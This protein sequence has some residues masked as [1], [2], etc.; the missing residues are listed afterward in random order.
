MNQRFHALS[1]RYETLLDEL[2]GMPDRLEVHIRADR[3]ITVNGWAN[4]ETL[5]L[6]LQD[7]GR[8]ER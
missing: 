6:L 5:D 7:L 1:K 4:D 3:T 8:R 2:Q